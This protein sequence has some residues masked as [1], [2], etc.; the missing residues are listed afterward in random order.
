MTSPLSFDATRLPSPHLTDS[1]EAWRKTVRG[2]VERE[3]MPYVNEWD[4][5][6][7]FPRE[8]H[9]K[10]A[11]IGL[12]GL[13]FPERYGGHSEDV[14]IF[15]SLIANEEL[16]RAG[17][18]GLCA[19]LMT[20]GIG[21]PPIITLGSDALK[22]R[23]APG[24]L[25]GEKLIAL[26]ITEPSGGSDVANLKAKAVRKSGDY[27]VNGEKTF[28][29]T[30]CRADYLTV[31]VRTGGEGAGGLSFLLIEADRPGV[32]RAPLKKMGWW[33]SDTASIH[34]DNVSVPADNLIGQENAGFAG[35]VANFNMERL[36]MAAQAIAFARVCIEDAADW[37]RDRQTFAKALSKH[38]V[39]RHKFAEMLRMTN[40]SQAYLN[41]CAWL[42]KT[43]ESPI[44]D[45]SLLKVQ[46]TRTMEFCAREAMQILGG[47]GFMRGCRVERIYREVRVM[48]IGGGSEEIM[49][50][51]AARQL[52]L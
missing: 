39:I 49:N 22:T 36:A 50:D 12:I 35:I 37:A 13:G 51:L 48:A 29:T 31:A 46:A 40:A 25:S 15:H 20:H 33:M 7:A 32:S 23:I 19:G 6:G 47:A 9:K 2:F 21:L 42:V 5:T 4:E 16:A 41:H 43:G 44:A 17:A 38:Q 3:I 28:I 26:C 14:D 18:G 30:G 8:L 11:D 10:A 24:V 27:I 52:D 1:H 45:L 34:F